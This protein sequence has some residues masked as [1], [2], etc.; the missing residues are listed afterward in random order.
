MDLIVKTTREAELAVLGLDPLSQYQCCDWCGRKAP[1]GQAHDRWWFHGACFERASKWGLRSL[2][3]PPA[4][5]EFG[6]D[7]PAPACSL[8]SKPRPAALTDAQIAEVLALARWGLSQAEI[9]R[10]LGVN[11]ASVSRALRKAEERSIRPA[12]IRATQIDLFGE[13]TAA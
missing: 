4:D 11:Q 2:Q 8:K 3:L 6:P 10:R 12:K 7:S 5:W 1:D 13:G 9:A